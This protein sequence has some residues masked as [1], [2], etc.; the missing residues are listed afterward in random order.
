MEWEAGKL[1]KAAIHAISGGKTKVLYQGKEW[2]IDLEKG[3]SQV[4]L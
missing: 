1:K 3:A 2:E 4:L